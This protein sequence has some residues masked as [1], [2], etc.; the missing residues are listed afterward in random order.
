MG[1]FRD[2]CNDYAIRKD[3]LN[4]GGLPGPVYV[5]DNNDYNLAQQIAQNAL[6][7]QAIQS[8]IAM[9]P[10]QLTD[11][12]KE[13]TN[14]RAERLLLDRLRGVKGDFKYTSTDFLFSH[15]HTD[16]V[17]VFFVH[18]G[19]GGHLEDDL[20]LYPSDKLITQ[21]RLIWSA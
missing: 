4:H 7:M 1:T 17:F 9:P 11:N 18:D 8:A 6:A 19:R 10:N 3:I 5:D 2:R 12:I 15:V 16:R 13:T 21:L 14:K 20:S